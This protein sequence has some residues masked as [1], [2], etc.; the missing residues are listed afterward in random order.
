MYAHL[1]R[2]RNH[3]DNDCGEQ[4]FLRFMKCA[5]F[6]RWNVCDWRHSV[7]MSKILYVCKKWCRREGHC[8][9]LSMS[10]S[11]SIP[12]LH[13]TLQLLMPQKTPTWPIST[14]PS[15]TYTGKPGCKRTRFQV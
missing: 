15:S 11:L 14:A 8:W 1:P 13:F 2:K 12:I 10:K 9:H 5:I 4:R 3:W 7:G 6:W